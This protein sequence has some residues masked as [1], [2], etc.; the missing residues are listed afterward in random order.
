MGSA[1]FGDDLSPAKTDLLR[2]LLETDTSGVENFGIQ[3]FPRDGSIGASSAQRR[4]W[5]LEQLHG[6]DA[7]YNSPFALRLRGPLDVGALRAGARDLVARHES[8]RT[9]V[10]ETDD[11]VVQI[12]APSADLDLP[13]TD[14]RQAPV[15]A[16][17]ELAARALDASANTPFRLDGE[18]LVRWELLRLADDDH[19]LFVNLHHII[20]DGWSEGV[21]F[22]ELGVLYSA[23]VTGT[24]SPLPDQRLHYADYARWEAEQVAGGRFESQLAYWRDR[25]AGA[26]APLALPF[27]RPP[28]TRATRA[29]GS[30]GCAVPRDLLSGHRAG[31]GGGRDDLSVSTAAIAALTVLLHR[32]T[33]E[34]DIV[35]GVPVANR[36][37]HEW[38]SVLGQFVNTVALRVTVADGASLRD[39][40]RETR[41]ALTEA[42][43]NQEVPFDRVVDAVDAPREPDRNPIFQ[44]LCVVNEAAPAPA[45]A[46]LTTELK[47]LGTHTAKFDLQLNVDHDASGLACAFEFPTDLFDRA[48]VERLAADYRAV[49]G[50]L[51][52]DPGRRVDALD[53]GRPPSRPLTVAPSTSDAVVAPDT[54]DDPPATPTELA[55]AEIWS[56]VLETPDVTRQS[57]FFR[58]GGGS[59]LAT[60]TVIRIRKRW[61]VDATVRLV[62]ETPVLHELAEQIDRRIG[63]P[64]P[65]TATIAVRAGAAETPLSFGQERLWFLNQYDP[66]DTSYNVVF[67]MEVGG[68][69]HPAALEQALNA[70]VARHEML[71]TTF[72]VVDDRPIQVV[73]PAS[74]LT[75]TVLDLSD[76]SAEDGFAEATRLARREA[77]T[78]FDLARGPLL[79]ATAYRLADQRFLL[80][81]ALHHIVID[82]WSSQIFFRE[83]SELYRAALTGAQAALPALPVQYGDHALWQR[84]RLT[85]EVL[86]RQLD[87]WRTTLADAPAV[88]ELPTDHPRPATPSYTGG[89]R[90]ALLPRELA[91][92]LEKLSR[93]SDTTMYM[94]LLA[95]FQVLLMRHSGQRDVLVGTTMAT[96]TEVEEEALIGFFVNT[97]VLRADLTGDPAFRELLARVREATLGA[98]AHQDLPFERL[99][100]ELRPDRTTHRTPIFQV[101]FDFQTDEP[102]KLALADHPVRPVDIGADSAHFDLTMAVIDTVDGLHVGVRYRDDLFSGETVER[103]LQRWRVLLEGIVENPDERVETLPLLPADERSLLL[104][105]W[106]TTGRSTPRFAAVHEMVESWAEATPDAVAL[107][108][109]DVRLTYRD[110]NARANQLAH[111]LGERGVGPDTGVALYV[112]RSI[113]AMVGILGVLKAGGYYVPLDVSYPAQRIRDIIADVSPRVFLTMSRFAPALAEITGQDHAPVLAMDALD[114]EISLRPTANPGVSLHEENLVYVLHTSG[115]TGRPKGVA[116]QHGAL[117]R[118]IDWYTT[119]TGIAPGARLLQFSSLGFDASF[120]EIFGGWHAGARVVLLPRDELRRD[121]EALLDLLEREEIEHL[122]APYS[123]LLNIAY[124]AVH[125]GRNRSLR[126]RTIVTG[127]EQLL[128]APDLVRWLAQLPGCALRNGYGPSETSVATTHW[129][130]GDPTTWPELPPIGRPITDADVY[131]LDDSMGPVPVGATGEVY[132]GGDIVARGYLNRPGLTAERF[133]PDPFGGVP[134]RRLYRTGDFARHRADGVLE[135]LGRID[136]QVKLRGYRIELGEIESCLQSHPEVQEAAVAVREDDLGRRLVG[137]VVARDPARAPGNEELRAY[138]GERLPEYM[139]PSTHVAVDAFSLTASGKLDRAAL[140][141][142]AV[143]PVAAARPDE[144][145]SDT[146]VALTKIWQDLFRTTEIGQHDNFFDLGGHSLLATRAI[147]RIRSAVGTKVLLSQVFEYPTIAELAAEI[148]R[149]ARPADEGPRVSR[150]ERQP[151]RAPVQRAE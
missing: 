48:T 112:D 142:D 50:D 17:E 22:H 53:V 98:F 95:A 40:L 16:R 43:A 119:E 147:A 127:G 62:F 129:L 4:L 143:A 8:L 83:L 86:A 42:A 115:S 122:E 14:L 137:Y 35:V 141:V 20:T 92:R 104:T 33:G 59:L 97:V 138:V 58:S 132:V 32:Y 149:T 55:L 113:E 120:C 124:W 67:A 2:K 105:Q 66:E 3:P 100:H 45:F 65:D 125:H 77:E 44:V 106:S 7:A 39:V 130:R 148:D 56:E 128:M 46:R 102:D 150:R 81:Y 70:L 36:T 136:N 25:L 121:A 101:L 52:N 103:W 145:L 85:D 47:E 94:T 6:A 9:T 38:E 11:D 107:V 5:F 1:R 108:H 41:S 68:A 134:A 118:I 76:L 126:L 89:T 139:V 26:A 60:R 13:L 109:E 144:P 73:A 74:D 84:G 93:E 37:R 140:P 61:G 114:A 57:H 10:A 131:V 28:G 99:V 116:M 63:R 135:F 88:L 23:R 78:P 12:I 18:P 111:W 82:D 54:E 24:A 31:D 110:L 19:Y 69:L 75:L 29:G 72:Q 151:L 123:G 91:A 90:T 64:E 96:R 87:Y 34:R 80:V 27:D 15:E 117:L 146:A 30:V 49:L 79:R 133:V 51:V 71:R 21:F